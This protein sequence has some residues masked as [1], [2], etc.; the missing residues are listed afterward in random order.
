MNAIAVQWSRELVAESLD[1]LDDNELDLLWRIAEARGRRVPVAELA[2]DLG[3]PAATALD[4]DFPG[5]QRFCGGDRRPAL[6]VVA[7]GTDDKGWYWLHPD[8]AHAFAEAIAAL[9]AG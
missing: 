4:Q 1:Q 6:P 9:R 3:L 2:R 7:G 8:H 5:L